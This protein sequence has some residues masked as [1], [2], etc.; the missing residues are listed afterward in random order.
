MEFT[1][2]GVQDVSP[3]TVIYPGVIK[4]VEWNQKKILQTLQPIIDF[5][6][7]NNCEIYVGRI[8][9]HPLGTG[10]LRNPLLERYC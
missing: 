2:Q 5:Q 9:R 4:G 1:H 6:K 10:Q 3:E 7:K 8:Q